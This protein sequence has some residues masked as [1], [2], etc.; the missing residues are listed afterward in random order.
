MKKNAPPRRGQALP[1]S[2]LQFAPSFHHLA[3]FARPSPFTRPNHPFVL[4]YTLKWLVGW[5]F[6][7]EPTSSHDFISTAGWW[8]WYG[9]RPLTLPCRCCHCSACH[10]EDSPTV[11]P[12]AAVAAITFR[13]INVTSLGASSGLPTPDYVLLRI[14]YAGRS[15]FAFSYYRYL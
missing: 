7:L 14:P 5:P 11:P 1:P 9:L 8:R 15:K 12:I 3:P 13:K 4:L 2:S 10:Y 6:T